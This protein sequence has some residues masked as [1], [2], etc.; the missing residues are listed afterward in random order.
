MDTFYIK[1]N[2]YNKI[3]QKHI[4]YTSMLLSTAI[5]GIFELLSTYVHRVQCTVVKAIL[6]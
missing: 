3:K 6:F 2:H 4:T 1:R 5:I